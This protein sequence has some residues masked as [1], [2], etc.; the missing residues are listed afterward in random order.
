[1]TD[2]QRLLAMNAEIQAF[3][4]PFLPNKPEGLTMA[5]GEGWVAWQTAYKSAWSQAH[6]TPETDAIR[7]KHGLVRCED[8]PGWRNA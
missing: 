2:K 5:D 3:V 6:K 1:M 7:I 8:A 4:A